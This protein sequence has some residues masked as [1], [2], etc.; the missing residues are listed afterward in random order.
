VVLSKKGR[1][2]GPN[3]TKILVISLAELTP[4]QWRASTKSAG[5]WSE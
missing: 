3:H 5:L 1:N 4:T 2:V